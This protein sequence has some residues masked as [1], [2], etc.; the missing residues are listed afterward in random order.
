MRFLLILIFASSAAQANQYS[1]DRIAVGSQVSQD[2]LSVEC[3]RESCLKATE[4]LIKRV[5]P[6]CLS[7]GGRVLVK[8]SLGLDT[9]ALLDGRFIC[10]ITNKNR[11]NALVCDLDAEG[12]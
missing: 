1:I 11:P 6:D 3:R 5:E 8:G 4:N 2:C 7:I 9:T 12:P 10:R